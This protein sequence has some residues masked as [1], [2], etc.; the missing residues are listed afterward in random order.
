MWEWVK[1][2]V[3][4]GFSLLPACLILQTQL[5]LLCTKQSVEQLLSYC[6]EPSLAPEA[7]Y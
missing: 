5:V 2:C 7:W 4:Q 1:S 6:D 3:K